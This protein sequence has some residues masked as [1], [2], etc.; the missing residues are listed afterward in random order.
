MRP[1]LPP[2]HADTPQQKSTLRSVRAAKI[3]RKRFPRGTRVEATAGPGEPG[4]GHFGTVAAHIP[5][6]N[7]QGGVLNVVWDDPNPIT[8]KVTISRMSAST[9]RVV[10]NTEEN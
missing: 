7:A 9:L 5:H 8:G 10:Q 1:E 4:N 3:V 2:P 6:T